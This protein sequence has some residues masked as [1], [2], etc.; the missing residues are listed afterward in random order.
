MTKARHVGLA[1]SST[2]VARTAGPSACLGGKLADMDP[3]IRLPESVAEVVRAQG[4][5]L[6]S[7]VEPRNAATVVLM[8]DGSS[9]GPGRLQI[10]LMRRQVTMAFAAGMAVFPGGG[11]DERDFETDFE[12]AGPTVAEWAEM[13]HTSV[14]LACALVCAAVRETFEECGVLL[15]GHRDGRT[16]SDVGGPDWESDRQ[17]LAAH[18][19]SLADVLRRRDLVL[20][21]DLLRPWSCWTTPEF[22]RRRYRSWFFV[23]V[24]PE[25][26]LT[27][28]VSSEAV[29]VEW[30]SVRDAIHRAD[31]GDMLMLPPQYVTCLELFGFSD[32]AE[33]MAVVKNS[34][35]IAP[36]V[37]FD[38]EGAFLVL[39]EQLISLG[40]SVGLQMYPDPA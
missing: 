19:H 12:W 8:R 21:S 7:A 30:I 38:D 33:T 5:G 25:G 18:S 40:H 34:E 29:A 16:V 1:A 28:D 32:T 24:L 39:P 3:T 15:A 14:S 11:V 6:S 31:R 22:E 36:S 13:L 10:H 35:S 23:A 2:V 17:L 9:P 20:R 37:G 4:T 27:R 26:Q